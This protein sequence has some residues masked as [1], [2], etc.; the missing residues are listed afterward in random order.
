MLAQEKTVLG[1][2]I[3]Y[4]ESESYPMESLFCKDRQWTKWRGNIY[5]SRYEFVSHER[6]KQTLRH[7]TFQTTD[8][9]RRLI[10]KKSVA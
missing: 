6:K 2:S 4:S 9:I 7:K 8:I 3:A 10:A 1:F 5:I